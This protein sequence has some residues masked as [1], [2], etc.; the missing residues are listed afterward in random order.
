MTMRIV[1]VFILLISLP[2]IA[3]TAKLEGNYLYK[4][5]TIRAATGALADLLEWEAQLKASEHYDEAGQERPQINW[6]RW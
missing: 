5:T 4:V 2:T 1:V 3:S 6:R